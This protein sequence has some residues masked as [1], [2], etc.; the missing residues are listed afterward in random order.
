M[1]KAVAIVAQYPELEQMVR[2]LDELD[3]HFG[4][5]QEFL[6]KQVKNLKKEHNAEA[7]PLLNSI[8]GFL[9]E[10]KLLPDNYDESKHHLHV[11]EEAG[12]VMVCDGSDHSGHPIL[13]FLSGIGF[14]PGSID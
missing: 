9:S 2:N 14:T 5:K 8:R 10:K 11:D 3:Q 13:Q 1:K 6:M 12:V 4:Q 7:E